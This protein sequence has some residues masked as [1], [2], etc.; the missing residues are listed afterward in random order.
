[1]GITSFDVVLSTSA[2][3]V[4][5]VVGGTEALTA[6]APLLCQ[7]ITDLAAQAA[8]ALLA[9]GTAAQ[10]GQAA[11]QQQQGRLQPQLIDPRHSHY[12]G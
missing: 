4:L 3:V 8:T 7:G 1:M 12:P 10:V 9:S 6:N 5:T 2:D 11:S